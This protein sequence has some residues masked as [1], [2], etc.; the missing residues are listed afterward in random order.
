MS[1]NDHILIA[2]KDFKDLLE[3]LENK[4]QSEIGKSFRSRCR[5]IPS[6]IEDVGLVPALSFCY[7]KASKDIY[8]K[9]KSELRKGGKIDGNNPTEKGYGIYFYLML[10]R[11]KE[12]KL[13]EETYL[14]DPIK[15]LE[16]I[17]EGKERVAN[18]L[19]RPYIVQ[20][21]KLSEAVFKAEG[22]R[23]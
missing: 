9:V 15:A 12:L 11:L 7:A 23:R 6:L 16:K 19:L 8:E 2:I 20:M 4:E 10:K 5:E 21:K 3:S 17:S 18:R 14:D 13:I 1:T 22:E